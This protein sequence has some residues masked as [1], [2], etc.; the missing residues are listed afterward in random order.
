MTSK[1]DWEKDF[2]DQLRSLAAP[3]N[4]DRATLAELRRCLGCDLGRALSRVGRLFNRV[5]DYALDDA[6]LV[7]TLFAFHPGPGSG[8]SLGEAFHEL[9]ARAG[10]DSIGKRFVALLDSAKEDLPGRLRQA[11]SLLKS[12]EIAL[13]WE[14]LLTDLRCWE[15]PSRRVQRDWARKFGEER[16]AQPPS[17]GTVPEPQPAA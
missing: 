5:P 13:D 9:R 7:A 8:G 12:K 1:K 14:Q 2:I 11:V 17:A 6:V 3:P 16:W 15:Q 10:S 4:P